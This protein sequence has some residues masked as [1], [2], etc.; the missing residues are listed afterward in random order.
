MKKLLMVFLLVSCIMLSSCF[1]L[2]F[3]KDSEPT[4]ESE[5][6]TQEQTTETD[7]TSAETTPET[8]ET[9]ETT[10]EIEPTPDP[11]SVMYG[12]ITITYD[13]FEDEYADAED[14]TILVSAYHQNAS[15]SIPAFPAAAAI[16]NDTLD[17]IRSDNLSIH[18]QMC[19]E[20]QGLYD[21]YGFGGIP[22]MY[23]SS[24]I[25]EPTY[26]SE[27]LICFGVTYYLYYGGAHGN[28]VLEAYTFDA[29]TGDFV[30]FDDLCSDPGVF[31]HFLHTEIIAQI[32]EIPPADRMVFEDYSTAVVSSF[33]RAAWMISDFE[34]EPSLVITYQAYDI[35][36][37]AA[38]L[39]TF[40]VPLSECLSYFNAYGASLFA[41]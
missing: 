1:E 34:S 26:V 31:E 41:A 13:F 24:I 15:V 32:E 12:E 23:E 40:S 11:N 6:E 27:R 33:D 14:G 36:P 25:L 29:R 28:V 10:A 16:I 18:E 39:P 30:S 9:T 5:T 21:D 19:L 20:A 38:G 35:A 7:P 37:Y 4:E 8:S 2:E 22:G 3:S 17:F